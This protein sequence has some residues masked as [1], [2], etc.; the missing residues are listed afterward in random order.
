MLSGMDELREKMSSLRASMFPH[1]E[2]EV[3]LY[4]SRARGDYNEESDWDIIVISKDITDNYSN[5]KTYGMPFV[6]LGIDYN[7][8]VSPLLYST[9]QWEK[10]SN[11]LFHYNV[12]RDKIRI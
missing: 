8:T 5:F 12:M 1:G 3:W 11:T 7:Q 6:E 4:G 2:G 9:D 10:E